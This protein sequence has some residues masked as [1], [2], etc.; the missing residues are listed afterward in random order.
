MFCTKCGTKNE[1]NNALCK[2]CGAKL[3][4]QVTNNS[5]NSDMDSQ[6]VVSNS[7]VAH[8]HNS[9]KIIMI[10]GVAI[11]FVFVVG[12]LLFGKKGSNSKL[13]DLVFTVLGEDQ[14]PDSLKEIIADKSAQPFQISYTLGEELYIAVGYGE[15][16]SGGYSI[17]VN[18]FYETKDVIVIDTMLLSPPTDRLKNVPYIPTRPYIMIKT[19]NIRDK[20]I[21]YNLN[22]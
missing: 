22:P 18:E 15:Q 6:S 1:D 21:E 5:G 13:G 14:Q 2:N 8:A 16:P 12:G 11:I 9:M 17:C 4:K 10:A 7:G 20:M 3:I 19:E